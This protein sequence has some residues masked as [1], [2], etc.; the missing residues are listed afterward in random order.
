MRDIYNEI[1]GETCENCERITYFTLK[2]LSVTMDLVTISGGVVDY[3][4]NWVCS[5]GQENSSVGQVSL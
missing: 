1:A 4:G 2:Q 3:E 5:C